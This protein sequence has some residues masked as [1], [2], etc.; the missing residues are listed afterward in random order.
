MLGW[1]LFKSRAA[2]FS[3]PQSE[4]HWGMGPLTVTSLGS[5]LKTHMPRNRNDGP[6]K[7]IQSILWMDEKSWKGLPGY[8]IGISLIDFLVVYF[9]GI[10]SNL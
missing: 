6:T 2:L 1:E 9:S 4:D 8:A 10:K 7:G 5:V 3:A